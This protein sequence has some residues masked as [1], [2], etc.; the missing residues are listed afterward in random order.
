MA[1]ERC[2]AETTAIELDKWVQALLGRLL[3][4]ARRRDNVLQV[5]N[6]KHK[7]REEMSMARLHRG[8]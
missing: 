5:R 2:R 1:R 4:E 8:N 3:R 6:K 7:P